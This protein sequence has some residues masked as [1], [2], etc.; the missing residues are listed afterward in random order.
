MEDL[1]LTNNW[2]LITTDAC[3]LYSKSNDIVL[4][5]ESESEPD[6]ELD[7]FELGRTFFLYFHKGGPLWAKSGAD[8]K[9]MILKAPPHVASSSTASQ[10]NGGVDVILVTLAFLNLQ[11]T[12]QTYRREVLNG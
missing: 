10:D 5:K 3:E 1:N 4:L 6:D 7:C 8:D 11:N 9:A 2:K 12:T